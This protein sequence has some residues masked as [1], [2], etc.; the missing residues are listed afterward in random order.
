MHSS[1]NFLPTCHLSVSHVRLGL[2]H[3]S[4]LPCIP[5]IYENLVFFPPLLLFVWAMHS[6]HTLSC[7][8]CFPVQN[9]RREGFFLFISI[10]PMQ[11]LMYK[12]N[13]HSSIH[14]FIQEPVKPSLHSVAHLE[15]LPT[16]L[17]LSAVSG[18]T[19]SQRQQ[20]CCWTMGTAI[21]TPG[22]RNKPNSTCASWTSKHSS[23]QQ[24]VPK[25]R[26]TTFTYTTHSV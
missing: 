9:H 16:R 13:V 4:R 21:S 5:H 7:Q 3:V 12:A 26:S 1:C 17:A 25:H 10:T 15:H 14:P 8:P 11:L 22:P 6:F 23:R 18:W 24:S 19:N 2:V 20:K